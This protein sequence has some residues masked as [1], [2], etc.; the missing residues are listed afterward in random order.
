MVFCNQPHES[1][2]N[3]QFMEYLAFFFLF[4]ESYNL[5]S[6][7]SKM[8]K[9]DLINLCIVSIL[10]YIKAKLAFDLPLLVVFTFVLVGASHMS[11]WPFPD[12]TH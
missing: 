3:V 5:P 6:F 9:I 1:S 4:S 8:N 10:V 7:K 2:N 11:P 12:I